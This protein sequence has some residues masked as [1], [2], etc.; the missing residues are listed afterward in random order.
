MGQSNR[1]VSGDVIMAKEKYTRKWLNPPTSEYTGYIQ[2]GMN[3]DQNWVGINLKIA[4]CFRIVNFD[5]NDTGEK[6]GRKAAVKKLKVLRDSLND[7]IGMVEKVD[8]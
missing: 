7:L 5:F 2:Y 8:V 4:D 3:I 6:K 1:I